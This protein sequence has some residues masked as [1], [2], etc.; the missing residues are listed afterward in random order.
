M[1]KFL[2]VAILF[3][4]AVPVHAKNLQHEAEYQNAWCS[5]MGGITEYVLPDHT[6]V[7]CLLDDYAVEMD[8]DYK[9]AEA[10]G[11]GLYYSEQTGRRPGIVLIMEDPEKGYKYLIRLLKSISMTAMKWRV[12]IVTPDDID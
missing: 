6:R 4:L 5:E 3:L 9:W 12:W 2:F 10:I 1:N 8:F 11:Q 7:D